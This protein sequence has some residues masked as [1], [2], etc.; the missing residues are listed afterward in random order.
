MNKQLQRLVNRGKDALVFPWFDSYWRGR[1]RGQVLCLLYHRIGDNDK[2]AF[3]TRGGSPAISQREF[4]HDMRFL[5]QQGADFRTFADLRQGRFPDPSRFAVIISFDD[6]F[7]DNYTVGMEVLQS[8]DV[9]GVFFQSTAFV[10]SE[11]LIWEHELYWHTRTDAASERFTR[12]VHDSGRD[13]PTVSGIRGAR[14]VEHLRENV[15]F[16]RVEQMLSEY[17]EIA[18]A[19]AEADET[20]RA[21]YPQAAHLKKAHELGHEIASHGHRHLKRSTIDLPTFQ[22]ELEQSSR[23]LT[24]LLG[25]APGA[26][27][28]P[29]NS[30]AKDDNQMV[31]RYFSQG[32]TVDQRCI[33]SDTPPLWMPRFTWPGP[34]RNFLRSRRW[35]LT[36]KI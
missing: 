35:L 32:V 12:F 34:A 4:E 33:S 30:Y 16:E 27:S 19:Q 15:A 8:L 18:G 17:R 5:K 21:I 31:S 22:S 25:S 13:L 10:D 7:L 14:L 29:F 20:A 23:A 6:C 2:T 11:S 36:G 9:K 28:F 26:F 24:T 1:L 3:L